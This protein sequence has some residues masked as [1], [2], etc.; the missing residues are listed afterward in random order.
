V[1]DVLLAL[2]VRVKYHPGSKPGKINSIDSLVRLAGNRQL[3]LYS[4]TTYATIRKEIIIE[5]P[6]TIEHRCKEGFLLLRLIRTEDSSE[7]VEIRSVEVMNWLAVG[8]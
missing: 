4:A 7:E 8:N 3:N 2:T 6:I 5:S 1:H